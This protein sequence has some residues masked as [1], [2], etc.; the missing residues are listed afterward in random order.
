MG[1]RGTRTV[2]RAG[3]MLKEAAG[4]VAG[5]LYAFDDPVQ[6]DLGIDLDQGTVEAILDHTDDRFG[7]AGY[8]LG[9]LRLSDDI[10]MDADVAG[11]YSGRTLGR[12]YIEI[13]DED[14]P[15][16]VLA[17]ELGHDVE[18]QLARWAVPREEEGI[19]M[20]R[21]FGEM[22][23][24][25]YQ[26]EVAE[27]F[28][29]VTTGVVGPDPFGPEDTRTWQDLGP[30]L[31][32]D[33][34]DQRQELYV[35]AREALEERDEDRLHKAVAEIAS[36]PPDTGGWLPPWLSGAG[37]GDGDH[38]L[39]VATGYQ[40]LD[41][42]QRALYNVT[43]SWNGQGP[44]G[45]EGG[46][47]AIVTACERGAG[48]GG[49]LEATISSAASDELVGHPAYTRDNARLYAAGMGNSFADGVQRLRADVLAERSEE[50]HHRAARMLLDDLETLEEEYQDW[51]RGLDDPVEEVLDGI[52]EMD[53]GS[54]IDGEETDLD[55]YVDVPHGVGYTLAAELH[56][57]GYEMT[58][59][60]DDPEQYGEVVRDA[61]R[62]V[63]ES[64]MMG[65]DDP[66]LVGYLDL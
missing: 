64:Q 66:D 49:L 24:Y 54:I 23:A 55:P 44:G 62:Y 12:A 33:L 8:D 7:H 65:R 58:D 40:E 16:S 61:V 31:S 28:D 42:Y 63:V 19:L 26:M 57:Q 36:M 30:A 29:A 51:L 46:G 35:Q 52:R 15:L 45:R 3:R 22:A 27:Q 21:T 25:L 10:D 60:V 53:Y 5:E 43:G 20:T 32:I 41:R 9:A 47:A 39:L 1:L 4:T 34:S 17:H 14:R 11:R 50:V 38:M 59:I 56:A 6:D 48:V 2:R 13:V 18:H 37:D